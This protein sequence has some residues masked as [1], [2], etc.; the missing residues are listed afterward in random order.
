MTLT[1]KVEIRAERKKFVLDFLKS[2]IPG[3]V[4]ILMAIIIRLIFGVLN[5]GWI[6]ISDGKIAEVNALNNKITANI[7]KQQHAKDSEKYIVSGIDISRKESDDAIFKEFLLTYGQYDS[8]DES[9]ALIRDRPAGYDEIYGF[10]GVT[11]VSVDYARYL[12]DIDGSRLVLP[13]ENGGTRNVRREWLQSLS[14]YVDESSIRTYAARAS[15]GNYTYYAFFDYH[16]E[17]DGNQ[18]VYP[19]CLRYVMN[20]D[21]R[22]YNFYGVFISE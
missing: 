5:S 6:E 3:F 22:M 2:G 15:S 18:F 4:I 12:K 14:Q 13:D 10:D 9:Y 17:I 19:V 11:Y 7:A 8:L 20:S 16:R 1:N 21:G